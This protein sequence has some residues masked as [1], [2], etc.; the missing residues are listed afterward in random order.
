MLVHPAWASRFDR[1]R[2][3]IR[4]YATITSGGRVAFLDSNVVDTL[5]PVCH[6]HDAVTDRLSKL[7]YTNEYYIALASTI[8]RGATQQLF[9]HSIKVIAT[10]LDYTVWHGACSE[11]NPLELDMDGT[12]QAFVQDALVANVYQGRLIAVISK[13]DDEDVRAVFTDRTD[14]TFKAEHVTA[15]KVSWGPKSQALTE[16]AAELNLG[17]DSFVFLDDNPIEINEVASAHPTV[18]TVHAKEETI[19]HEWALDAWWRADAS[20]LKRVKQYAEQAER[21]QA[22]AKAPTYAD[23]IKSLDLETTITVVSSPD[24]PEVAR[25]SELSLRTNQYNS[26][27]IRRDQQA[28]KDFLQG[29]GCVFVG[30]L[31]D[32]FGDY[33]LVTAAFVK[34]TDKH[35]EVDSLLMSCRAFHRG[36]ELEL[37]RHVGDFAAT[38]GLKVHLRYATSAKNGLVRQFF[39]SLKGPWEEERGV[40]VEAAV[41]QTLPETPPSPPASRTPSCTVP[42]S[43]RAL[44]GTGT[45]VPSSTTL[46]HDIRALDSVAAIALAMGVQPTSLAAPNAAVVQELQFGTKGTPAAHRKTSQSSVVAGATLTGVWTSAKVEAGVKSALTSIM[47]ANTP[48]ATAPLMENGLTSLKAVQFIAA[49]HR[50]LGVELPATLVF[51]YPTVTAIAR[52]VG[53]L[54]GVVGARDNNENT[55]N[56][57]SRSVRLASTT[58]AVPDPRT[59]IVSAPSVAQ[60]I[61]N[62]GNGKPCAIVSM[63]CKFPGGNGVADFWDTMMA[64]RRM[65]K[66]QTRWDADLLAHCGPAAQHGCFIDDVDQF[67]STI[68][69]INPT[70]AANMDP[71]QRWALMMSYEALQRADLGD[72]FEKRVGV[73]VAMCNYDWALLQAGK[74]TPTSYTFTGRAPSVCA[75]RVSYTLGLKG[76]ALTIDTACSSTLVCLDLA[77]RALSDGQCDHALVV[78]TSLNLHPQTVE[79]L[80]AAGQLSKSGRCAT[81]DASADG[82][83]RSEG[84]GAIVLS[85]LATATRRLAVVRATGLNQDGRSASLSA[86]HGLSQSQL[87]A[88]TLERFRIPRAAV[89]YIETHGSG[90][91]LGDAVEADAIARVFGNGSTL[92]TDQSVPESL[93]LGALKTNVGHLEAASGMAALVKAV[94]AL[95]ARCVPP[96]ASLNTLNPSIRLPKHFHIPTETQTLPVDA[97]VAVNSFGMSGTNAFAVLEGPKADEPTFPPSHALWASGTPFK[98]RAFPWDKPTTLNGHV[99]AKAICGVPTTAVNPPRTAAAKGTLTQLHA[100]W[101]PTPLDGRA[102]PRGNGIVATVTKSTR[103]TALALGMQ[104]VDHAAVGDALGDA[105]VVVATEALDANVEAPTMLVRLSQL[106]VSLS[107]RATRQP[108][109]APRAKLTLVVL[110][111]A[112]GVHA[113]AV[114]HDGVWGWARSVQAELPALRIKCID[115][116]GGVGLTRDMLAMELDN[117]EFAR[118][119]LTDNGLERCVARLEGAPSPIADTT[120]TGT[121]APV[122]GTYVVTGGLGGLGLVCAGTLARLGASHIVLLSRSGKCRDQTLT[123]MLAAL[124]TQTKVSVVVANCADESAMREVLRAPDVRGV[125]HAAGVHGGEVALENVT[126]ASLEPVYAKAMGAHVLDRLTAGRGLDNFFVFSSIVAPLGAPRLAAYCAAN[127]SAAAVVDRRRARGDAACAI[128]LGPVADVGMATDPDEANRIHKAKIFGFLSLQN[129]ECALERALTRQDTTVLARMDLERLL[130]IK[131]GDAMFEALQPSEEEDSEET[132][133]SHGGVTGDLSTEGVARAVRAAVEGVCMGDVT[134]DEPLMDQGVDSLAAI[135]LGRTLQHMLSAVP[136]PTPATLLFELP[137]LAAISA[138]ALEHVGKLPT[139][140]SAARPASTRKTRKAVKPTAADT[141]IAIVGMSCRYPGGADGTLDTLDKFWDFVMD[142]KKVEPR[143]ASSGRQWSGPNHGVMLDDI[144]LFDSKVFG[145]CATEAKELDP[146]H[147]L[148]LEDSLLAIRN[149]GYSL[150][151]IKGRKVGVFLAIQGN[152]EYARSNE[153]ASRGPY[154]CTG[155]IPSFGAGRIAFCLGVHGPVQAIDA[156]CA[157][158]L[159]AVHTATN[160]LKLGDCELAIVAGVSLLMDEDTNQRNLDAGFLGNQVWTKSFDVAGAG[161]VRA[162]GCGAVVLQ[163]LKTLPSD[164]RAY[165]VIAG[166]AVEHNGRAASMFAPNIGAQ[167]SLLRRAYDVAR[168]PYAQVGYLE[169]HGT[170]T[171]LGD[172]AEISAAS[173]VL[174]N[175]VGNDVV[176]AMHVGSVKANF[177]HMEA[178][179]GLCGLIKAA[180]VLVHREVPPNAQLQKINPHIADV[181][182]RCSRTMEFNTKPV[183][184]SDNTTAAGVSAFGAC[185]TIAHIVL[186]QTPT[187][188]PEHPLTKPSAPLNRIRYPFDFNVKR[189]GSTSTNSQVSALPMDSIESVR[190]RDNSV[191]VAIAQLVEGVVGAVQ[192]AIT[193]SAAGLDSLGAI[194]LKNDLAGLAV[195]ISASGLLDMTVDQIVASGIA[196]SQVQARAGSLAVAQT[197]RQADTECPFRSPVGPQGNDSLRCIGTA[198]PSLLPR[199]PSGNATP[200]TARISSHPEISVEMNKNKSGVKTWCV[201]GIDGEVMALRSL[202]EAADTPYW[203][204]TLPASR[205]RQGV[206][207][208]LDL[209]RLYAEDIVAHLEADEHFNLLG[210]SFGVVVAH[211][212]ANI[213]ATSYQRRP[214]RLFLLDMQVSWPYAAWTGTWRGPRVEAAEL[215]AR[216]FSTD[217][218]PA[219]FHDLTEEDMLETAAS[220]RPPAMTRAVWDA[221]VHEW[222]SNIAFLDGIATG[223]VALLYDGPTV[224]VRSS[225]DEFEPCVADVQRFCKSVVLRRVPGSHF[226]MVEPQYLDKTLSAVHAPLVAYMFTGQGSQ[227]P[228]MCRDLFDAEPVFRQKMETCVALAD[229]VGFGRNLLEVI[230]ESRELSDTALVQP[231]LFAV[232]V[233]LSALLRSRGVV[234]AVVIGHSLGEFSAA[235]VAG[236]LSLEDGMRLIVARSALCQACPPQEGIMVATRAS[237]AQARQAIAKHPELHDTVSI[238]AI[239]SPNSVVF[240][241]RGSDVR[242]LL[243]QELPTTNT[244]D[245]RV[246]HAFHSPLLSPMLADFAKVISAV[247][248]SAPQVPFVSCLEGTFVT[249]RELADVEHW[250]AHVMRTVDFVA[251]VTALFEYCDV[252]VE[253]GP[254]PTLTPAAKQVARAGGVSRTWLATIDPKKSDAGAYTEALA[255][256]Q[257]LDVPVSAVT[258]PDAMYAPATVEDCHSSAPTPVAGASDATSGANERDVLAHTLRAI[259]DV[260][261]EDGGVDPDEPLDDMGVDSLQKLEIRSMLLSPV[262]DIFADMATARTIASAVAMALSPTG[263]PTAVLSPSVPTLAKEQTLSAYS[264]GAP[265]ISIDTIPESRGLCTLVSGTRYAI[266]DA[267][268]NPRFLPDMLARGGAVV[269]RSAELRDAQD[270]ATVLDKCP[271][272]PCDYLDGISPRTV[273]LPGV[274]TSTEYSAQQDMAVHNE[275]SYCSFMP[276]HIAFFCVASA[277]PNTGQTP[278]AD[279]C[280]ILASLDPALVERFRRHGVEYTVNAPSRGQG[281]GVA[282]QDMYETDDRAEVEALCK[283]RHVAVQWTSDGGLRTTRTLPA[284]RRHPETNEE[285]WCNHAHLFHPSDL[286]VKTQ[287]SIAKIFKEV[288][289][290]P[291]YARFGDG[292]PIPE[293]DLAAVRQAQRDNMVQWDWQ[294][295]DVMLLDNFRV[296]HGRRAFVPKDKKRSILAALLSDGFDKPIKEASMA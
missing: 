66:V 140:T 101:Y 25:L 259:A 262:S 152:P 274:F 230:F 81:F 64:Q 99:G 114:A 97:L 88:S 214:H 49:L 39:T 295:G 90:T 71:Q 291:K 286:P 180:L 223:H 63:T 65:T 58:S 42:P 8:A 47:G 29:G 98:L 190:P 270:F 115:V 27:G 227:Y 201:H 80:A 57:A 111:D 92:G 261:A 74:P 166:S 102:S 15:W 224:L 282:W 219:G 103:M 107:Q 256:L 86:P 2:G 203:G 233:S 165:A 155:K 280:A 253:I 294:Q 21:K 288:L 23:F 52:H 265:G 144:D 7:P 216:K 196:Q 45:R 185:G 264:G 60:E 32:K 143:Q 148:I 122:H 3:R 238:A 220:L 228:G 158:S 272:K 108:G 147:R 247:T 56:A 73:W 173:R 127:A 204:L 44:S 153:S 104:I 125:V 120:S 176:P 207:T 236:V 178:A 36:V 184:L 276:S 139:V 93:V 252:F 109:G 123:D 18:L 14:M 277:A 240:A 182:A 34:Q 251:G 16:L 263:D 43:A 170:A 136:W 82:Y 241:G 84:A 242:S 100:T 33:G 106:A 248:F 188:V 105:R 69:N 24:A 257:A 285:F 26:S 157:S 181:L 150:A 137:T 138:F 9:R 225:H 72:L 186:R 195:D 232:E 245:L 131:S 19:H 175:E 246:S 283:A 121:A 117:D 169:A 87:M 134:L 231:A 119:V 215:A 70:E 61:T 234:P 20:P 79:Q 255:S 244:M 218:L 209:A 77:R 211:A 54:L 156:A 110:S 149:A 40:L 293:A 75:G 10:D 260:L 212:M 279:S 116:E 174:G 113:R 177:G 130:L 271:G 132:P 217:G 189:D 208:L 37:L 235:V 50:A 154:S 31:R 197:Q 239:N 151:D 191:G 266:L 17:L 22:L 205:N 179:G 281:A 278:I 38:L 95:N 91:L 83:C 78:A 55:R 267:L 292:T 172:P 89:R 41:L 13:N 213:L 48:G 112:F 160:A 258:V 4:R 198:P 193:L 1:A 210:Y 168:V 202:A 30:A 200:S 222:Q 284:T 85:P 289:A 142:G 243:A 290:F 5:Y 67:D 118:Y 250:K 187:Q 167:Q 249:L 68:F 192:G 141:D 171:K 199:A 28:V 6:F 206:Q 35:V 296:C 229:K 11:K 273:V 237:P 94:L 254:K 194:Q 96:N 146:Q 59:S 53:D 268:A 135:E 129:L 164:K 159:V 128:L 12:L 161:Y 275:M 133:S 183:R 124:Q 226:T 62:D 76:P 287:Q 126:P 163:P 221:I 46:Y 145:I 269:L 51:D 162:D